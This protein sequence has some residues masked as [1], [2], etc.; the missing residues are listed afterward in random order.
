MAIVA[1]IV[2]VSPCP[3]AESEPSTPDIA[4]PSLDR[5]DPAVRRQVETARQQFDLL[6]T[7]PEAKGRLPQ[8]LGFM[9]ELYVAYDLLLPALDS[10]EVLV[11]LLPDEP[12]W[13]Y[14][15]GYIYVRRGAV[16]AA[17]TAL[18]TSLKLR[19]MLAATALRLAN[20]RRDQGDYTRSRQLYEIAILSD[21]SCIAARYGL[22][23]VARRAGRIEAAIKQFRELLSQYPTAARAR[24]GL[25]LALRSAGQIEAAEGQLSQVDFETV[26]LGDWW[27]CPDPYL[28]ALAAQTTGSAMHILR[29]TQA[30]FS[31]NLELEATEY[32]L[33]VE[34]NTQDPVAHKN[35][36]SA[37][38]R[39][40]DFEAAAR[41]YSMALSLRPNDAFSEYDLGQVRWKQQKPH[42]A[43]N[44]FKAAV[45]IN[46]S[47]S[48]AHRRL[49][50]IYVSKGDLETALPHLRRVTELDPQNLQSRAQLAMALVQSNRPNEAVLAIS[51]LLA[52]NPP[53]DPAA[54]LSLAGLMASLGDSKGAEK[55][56]MS[57]AQSAAP[58]PIRARAHEMLGQVRLNEGL[59]DEAITEY[60]EAL[61]LDPSS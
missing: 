56:F 24:Y 26:S 8:A 16:E 44:H 34:S 21:S 13:H 45:R 43:L 51:S 40:E 49:A 55:Y 19:P 7:N 17:Q 39:L 2:T 14:L 33:A 47:F 59:R 38:Y 1:A 9:A 35:L 58:D 31:G 20:L 30:R 10:L 4:R 60:N 41:H 50:E 53:A 6:L 46:P 52:E 42:E 5:L 48:L 11:D 27:G 12:K 18:A 28:A 57:V 22:G 15:L 25:G 61:R 3:A 36:A 32:R 29:G 23:E 37:L 54:L